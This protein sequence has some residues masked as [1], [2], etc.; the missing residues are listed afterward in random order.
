MHMST[1][2]KY[3]TNMFINMNIHTSSYM[4]KY[5]TLVDMHVCIKHNDFLDVHRS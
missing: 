4:H 2:T 3:S 5:V 1:Y